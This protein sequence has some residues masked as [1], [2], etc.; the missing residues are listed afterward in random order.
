MSLLQLDS[1]AADKRRSDC[2]RVS[3]SEYIRPVLGAVSYLSS[4]IFHSCLPTT[5]CIPNTTAIILRSPFPPPK[6]PKIMG[7]PFG[8]RMYKAALAETP[9]EAFNWKLVYAVICFGLMVRT[10]HSLLRLTFN[11]CLTFTGSCSWFG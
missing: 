9:R 11:K 5:W 10:F 4:R 3:C 2:S 8:P 1:F 6:T 7:R